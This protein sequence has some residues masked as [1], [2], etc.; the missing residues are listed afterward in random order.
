ML[1]S[2]GSWVADFSTNDYLG[3]ARSPL[4]GGEAASHSGSGGSRLLGGNSREIELLERELADYYGAGDSL[5]FNSGYDANLGCLSSIP[6]RGDLVFYD[7]LSHASIRDGLSLSRAKSVKFAH[8]DLEDLRE[9]MRRIREAGTFDQVYVVTESVF[10]M[11]GDR[12][13]LGELLELCSE[14]N[15]LLILDEAHRWDLHDSTQKY[16]R[17]TEHPNLFLRLVTFGKAMG[18]HGAAVLC[19][20]DLKDYLINFARSFIYTTA[21]PPGLATDLSRIHREAR[22]GRLQPRIESLKRVIVF[23]Q[24]QAGRRGLMGRIV[25][26]ESA[27]QSLR[28]G[29]VAR[30]RELAELLRDSGYFVKP[31][32]APTVPEGTERLRICLNSLHTFAELERLW[33]IVAEYLSE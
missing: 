25:E 5:V 18:L 9:R 24:E 15:A 28:V 23:F 21:L 10:S 6:Q 33:D 22:E 16:P 12:P 32:Y 3:L 7:E 13:D 26:T 27:V 1:E 19:N 11:D 31:I 14:L 20:R 2:P 17:Y 30:T 8:N 4:S 29:G